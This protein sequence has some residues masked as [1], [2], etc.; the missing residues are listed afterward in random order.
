MPCPPSLLALTGHQ[1][2][3]PFSKCVGRKSIYSRTLINPSRFDSKDEGIM[4]FRNVGTAKRIKSKISINSVGFL[5]SEVVAE[6]VMK[7]SIFCVIK[8]CSPLKN[9]STFQLTCYLIHTG[10]LV[11]SF[12]GP[13]NRGEMFD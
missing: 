1:P 5:G 8:P 11:G 3:Q 12:F 9:Q 10:L 13:E 7:T 4:H 6:V 2:L